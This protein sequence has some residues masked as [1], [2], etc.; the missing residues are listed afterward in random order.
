[1]QRLI[2]VFF[3]SLAFSSDLKGD[4]ED[5]EVREMED[6]SV[7]REREANRR[8]TVMDKQKTVEET[9]EYGGKEEVIK[10]KGKKRKVSRE[11]GKSA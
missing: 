4:N 2:F 11:G 6:A 5:R 8:G 3:F 9:E 7:R 1:M 10:K